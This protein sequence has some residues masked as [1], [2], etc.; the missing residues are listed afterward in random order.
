MLVSLAMDRDRMVQWMYMFYVGQVRTTG[1]LRS[2]CIRYDRWWRS[3]RK[4]QTKNSSED[5]VTDIST[6][7]CAGRDCGFSR[8][9]LDTYPRV[10]GGV[11]GTVLRMKRRERTVL[12]VPVSARILVQGLASEVLVSDLGQRTRVGHWILPQEVPSFS[13]KLRCQKGE[14]IHM[15][16]VPGR[17]GPCTVKMH[18]DT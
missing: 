8:A 10:D 6:V 4:W 3:T 18:Y 12:R 5:S 17:Y 16:Q 15:V 9:R 7:S 14:C 2:K 1:S 13:S 11:C